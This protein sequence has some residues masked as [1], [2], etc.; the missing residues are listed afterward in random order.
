MNAPH[1]AARPC[2]GRTPASL[3]RAF[4][5][6]A[7]V[8]A[9]SAAPPA[10]AAP[11]GVN[12]H[13]PTPE[14]LDAIKASGANWVRIDFLWS[15][16]EPARG[17]FQ[18]G[19][20]DD[21]V[22]GALGRGMHLYAT[23]SDTPAWATDGAA[24]RGVPR[25]R[26]DWYDFCFR[27]AS[28]YR[29][30][31]DFW[32]MWNEP[33]DSRFWAGGRDDYI[34][35]ILKTGGQAI[36][37][38]SS[39]ARVCGPELANLQSADWDKW[40]RDVLRRAGGDLDVVTHHV[41][42]NGTS[43]RSVI[44]TLDR[45]SR[46]PWDPP[47]V[48]KVLQDNGWAGRP[49][50]L[51]ETGCGSGVAPDGETAQ[52]GFVNDL[53]AGL[54]GPQRAV[55]WVDKT[56]LY[57]ISDDPRFPDAF[58]LLGPP[59]T[60]TAK[61][62]YRALQ[63]VA[64]E[65]P[66]DDAEVVRVALPAWLPPAATAN[67]T[68]EVRN[69]GTTTWSLAGGYRL[70][71]DGDDAPLA[72]VRHDLAAGET[73]APGEMKT[74]ILDLLAPGAETVP[75][76]PLHSDWR[77]VREGAWRFGETA[78]ASVAVSRAA[79][80]KESY[81]PFAAGLVDGAGRAWSSDVV[82]HNRAST[83]LSARVSFLMPGGDNEHAR[84]EVVTVAP[85]AS[86]VLADIVTRRLG[87]SGRGVLRVAAD[88]GDLVAGSTTAVSGG[89]GRYAAFTPAELSEA[90]IPA[91]GEGRLLRLARSADETAVRTDL[92]LLNASGDSTSADVELLDDAGATLGRRSYALGA[93]AVEYIADAF[94]EAGA[95][96]VAHGQAVVRPASG[97]AGVHAWAMTSDARSGDPTIAAPAR[98]TLEPFLLAPT[99]AAS[100]L[101]GGAW[102]TDLQL[103]SAG[104]APAD[105]TLT[106][107]T[108]AG[109]APLRRAVDLL[110]AG[111]AGIAVER[112]PDSL[113]SFRRSG[114]IVVTPHST[115]V[116]AVATTYLTRVP[117]PY[118]QAFAMVPVSRAV[119][120][121]GGCL[122]FPIM[123]EKAP[124]GTLTHLGLVNLNASPAFLEMRIFDAAGAQL[125]VTSLRLAASEWR[126]VADVLQ[127][128]PAVDG[129]SCY[130]VLR[131]STAGARF[132]A[133]A[134]VIQGGTGDPMQVP[135]S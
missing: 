112:A 68:V 28:R 91:G 104:G 125:R 81:L 39:T 21:V 35:G 70:A 62:A 50:W 23:I 48:R 129:Q 98:F 116:A 6:A 113:F 71:A 32:G 93:L 16:V 38:A 114:A 41:Y 56:F 43:A 118:G 84:G 119:G 54:F 133:Y 53:L 59:P 49:F 55:S 86:L 117:T 10:Y 134:T 17:S 40:L 63:H 88:S 74:F 132:V 124:G 83:A 65:L 18:W 1:S 4:A 79:P 82:L 103:V 89:G 96:A 36:H 131:A 46:Y 107:L 2:C 69:S 14:V 27:A 128:V 75:G 90:A 101:R 51:T 60:L 120:D 122:L 105:V 24:G 130:A 123:R 3:A 87:V 135:C 111:E 85:G 11:Y 34:D 100:R 42:P 37:A 121:T 13:I 15:L 73:V 57:E 22:E 109:Q 76:R 127:G 58:G 5:L 61:A 12:A 44:D 72:A 30:R 7:A 52:A 106:L 45:G 94:G 95:A 25:D 108:P 97:A 102:R 8:A 115:P 99:E 33:N 29:G 47:S 20:Y 19:T 66:V 64:A 126:Q 77:M 80:G 78:L 31:I 67:G 110:V 9:L 92:L 26:A